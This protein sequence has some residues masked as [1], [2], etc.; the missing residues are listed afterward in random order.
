MGHRGNQ[1]DVWEKV[2]KEGGRGELRRLGKVLGLAACFTIVFGVLAVAADKYPNGCAD[3]HVKD[4]AFQPLMKKLYPKHMPVGADVK[5]C[6]KCHKAGSKL[7]L[8]K[9]MHASHQKAK[10]AC[11]ACHVMKDGKVTKDLKGVN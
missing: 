1:A 10:I 3:C 11:D 8:D 9:K 7:A 4:L 5:G 6:L 2:R